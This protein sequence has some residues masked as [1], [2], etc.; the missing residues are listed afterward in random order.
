MLPITPSLA[1]YI[2]LGPSQALKVSGAGEGLA[3]PR[4]RRVV[5]KT[6]RMRAEREME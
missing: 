4:E 3:E 6:L 2:T 5:P 1:G